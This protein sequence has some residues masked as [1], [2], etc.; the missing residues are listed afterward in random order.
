MQIIIV[1]LRVC[2]N[3]PPKY[4]SSVCMCVCY[5]YVCVHA[6]DILFKFVPKDTEREKCKKLCYTKISISCLLALKF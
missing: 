1:T 3:I 2:D 6:L 5:T 4:V